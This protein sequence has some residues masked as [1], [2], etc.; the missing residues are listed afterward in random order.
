MTGGAFGPAVVLDSA[1]DGA[2][3]F[4]AGAAL[5]ALGG[6]CRCDCAARRHER[7]TRACEHL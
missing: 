5:V 3:V 7:E 1:G 6:C 4:S 2:G